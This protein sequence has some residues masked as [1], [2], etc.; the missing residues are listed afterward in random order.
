MAD[1]K[2][3]LTWLLRDEVSGTARKIDGALKGAAGSAKVGHSA[4]AGLGAAIGSMIN[5]LTLT[6]AG[7]GALTVGVGMAIGKAK[8]HQVAVAKLDEVLKKGALGYQL[9]RAQLDAYIE[10]QTELG[11]TVDDTTNSMA[12]LIN[13]TGD[14][15]RAQTFEAA[16]QDL[17]RLKG[18]SLAE[19]TDAMTK[20]EGGRFRML[21]SLG[22]VLQKGATATDALAA[23]QKA[24]AGQSE[25]Y[26]KTFQGQMD[27]MNAKFDDA[28]TKVGAQ[29]LPILTH[30]AGFFA[31]VLIPAIGKVIEVIATLVSWIISAVNWFGS[32]FKATDRADVAVTR[33][34]GAAGSAIPLSSKSKA[35]QGPVLGRQ[36]GGPVMAGGVY[37]V[38]ESGPETLLMGSQP[39]YVIP[40]A[41]MTPVEIPV[42]VDGQQLA[43][44]VDRRLYMIG[45][46]SGSSLRR[47]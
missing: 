8:E 40:H 22:I 25:A 6:I 16:A 23:V 44:I 10:K 2:T 27:K 39:G 12:L 29:L 32:L 18:I 37:T 20:I 38:G 11:F 3:T 15:T 33:T 46:T 43:R 24:A 13:A 47:S 5:P 41:G 14:V 19:A 1:T 36:S 7:L 28:M 42:I 30:L 45:L 9:S 17:A 21:A 35:A 26:G 4:F 31:D 34:M